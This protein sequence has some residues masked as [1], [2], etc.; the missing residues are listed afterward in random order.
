MR[1]AML[2][3]HVA[4]YSKPHF[5]LSFMFQMLHDS[6]SEVELAEPFWP[7]RRE[8]YGSRRQIDKVDGELTE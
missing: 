6:Q 7:R 3:I 5:L 4:L 1:G 8:V 2:T